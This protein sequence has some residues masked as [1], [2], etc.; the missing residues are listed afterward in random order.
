MNT[1]TFWQAAVPVIIG[2]ALHKLIAASARRKD[3][4]NTPYHFDF[5]FWW[6]DNWIS[7]FGHAVLMIAIVLYTPDIIDS[8]TGYEHTPK[9]ITGIITALSG[10]VTYLVLGFASAMPMT[11]FEKK[12]REVK[13]KL[14]IMKVK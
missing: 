10:R 9:Q 13:K 3:S 12:T 11:F 2:F 8:I 1:E 4:R 6:H 7:I 14:N 5:K